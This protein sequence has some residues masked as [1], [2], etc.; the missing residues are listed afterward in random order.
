MAG[1]GQLDAATDAIE[2]LRVVPRLQ[3]RYRM[4]RRR[5]RE[6]QRSSSL[7]DVLPLGDRNENAKLLKGHG[8]LLVDRNQV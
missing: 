5:L 6:V 8:D 1:L 7:R 4:A 3:C 2:E